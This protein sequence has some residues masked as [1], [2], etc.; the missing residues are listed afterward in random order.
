MVPT[1]GN[2]LLTGTNGNDTINALDGDDIINSRLGYDI[3]DGGNGNDLLIVDYSSNP[4]TGTFPNAGISG[5]LYRLFDPN[6]P[7]IPVTSW[8]GKISAYNSATGIADE[9]YFSNIERF[10]ITGTDSDDLLV[11]GNGNDT[12]FGGKGDDTINNNDGIDSIDGGP[13]IDTLDFANFSQETVNLNINETGSSLNLANGSTIRRVEYFNNL[14]TGTGNDFIDF[15]QATNNTINSG[16]GD[17]T[18]N[19]GLGYDIVDGGVG[20][21]L[22]IVDYSSNV[23]TNPDSTTGITS[24]INDN[25]TGSFDGYF[26]GTTDLVN[27][28]NIERFKITGTVGDDTITTGS[29]KDIIFGLDGNDNLI[30]GL[31]DDSLYGGTGNDS[32]AGENGQDYVEGGF[33]NDNISGGNASDKLYGGNGDDLVDGGDDKDYLS[34]D[35]GN[36]SLIG[37]S[38]ADTLIGG[39]GA[40]ILVGGLGLD[41]LTGGAGADIFALS[42]NS[43]IDTISDFGTGGDKLQ[44]SA[45]DF[46]GGLAAGNLA[47]S[48]FLSGSSVGAGSAT[49]SVGQFLYNTNSGA[50]Y[51][52]ANGAGGGLGIQIATLATHPSLSTSDFSV[53]V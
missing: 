47:G 45:S 21:D 43:G 5:Y 44:I 19:A 24:A 41:S 30:G 16:S 3:V 8:S 25:G 7:N 13:G 39:A 46:G 22:L 53:V 15:T 12:V 4:S 1:N 38:G 51:F 42:K 32:I 36:D 26:F 17:D 2:D 23:L 31:G 34:G 9:V 52:D 6:N 18:I 20:N 50:L 14:T 28:S 11:T 10:K 27:F 48:R 37:G 33:G 29:G 40:D 35:A 49:G